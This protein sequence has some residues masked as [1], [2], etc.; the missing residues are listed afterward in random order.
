[1]CGVKFAI[2]LFGRD[3]KSEPRVLSKISELGANNDVELLRTVAT[4]YQLR[5]QMG[6]TCA[7]VFLGLIHRK[8]R[9]FSQCCFMG[10]LFL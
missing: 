7:T 2:L 10:A 6:Y 8:L 1:M 3:P 5:S 9:L 4:I